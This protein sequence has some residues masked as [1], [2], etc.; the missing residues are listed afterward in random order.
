MI[1]DRFDALP[2]AHRDI[3]REA[4]IAAFG[5]APIGAI[6]AM[7]GGMTTASVYRVEVGRRK[8]LLRIEGEPSPL[9]NPH[10]YKAMAIAAEA[11]IAPTIHYVDEVARVA[12]MDFVEQVHLKAYP[13]GPAALARALGEL[14]S[15][16][17][18]TPVF[19]YYVNYPDIVARLFAHVRRTGLFADGVL[20]PHVRRL[21]LLG[22]AYE[23]GATKPVSSH[24]DPTPGNILFDG[25]RLWLID[26]ESAFRNDPLIDVAIVLDGLVRTPDLEEI[27]LNAWL[28]RAPD[29]DIRARLE[30]TQ[31]LTRLYYAGVF[32]SASAAAAWVKGDTDLSVPSVAEF[33]QAVQTGR[34]RAGTPEN[35]HIRGKMFLASFLSGIAT[36]GFGGPA[37]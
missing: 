2:A 33:Q 22:K 18:A 5:M 11:R 15:R 1:K 17:Q 35:W 6:A 36:P 14:F 21:E 34:L 27:F 16:V 8:Y 26:W 13:G 37:S 31:A 7:T 29:Q 19:P 9:R 24:N 10:Q 4:L 28:G 30:V 3:A 23:A 25:K 20:D 32:L 12:V